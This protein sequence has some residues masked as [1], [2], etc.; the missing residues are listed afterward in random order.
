MPG[1]GQ[2]WQNRL[3]RPSSPKLR[4]LE[5]S[6]LKTYAKNKKSFL[7]G[8]GLSKS[9][10]GTNYLN[11]TVATFKSLTRSEDS[12]SK[13]KQLDMSVLCQSTN[14]KES[15]LVAKKGLLLNET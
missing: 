3:T 2:L 14:L 13:Q 12:P 6:R 1:S 9:G 5:R 11:Q 15:L 7:Q 4:S 8:H 10:K